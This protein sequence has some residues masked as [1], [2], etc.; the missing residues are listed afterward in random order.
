MVLLI[1]EYKEIRGA[2]NG[3][4]HFYSVKGC[5]VVLEKETRSSKME[6]KKVSCEDIP[7][8]FTIGNASL[9][10]KDDGCGVKM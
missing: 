3:T 9:L 2:S 8:I 4:N 6:R 1:P 7:G 5:R 10:S